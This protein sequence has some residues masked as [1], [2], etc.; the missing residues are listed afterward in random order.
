MPDLT[1]RACRPNRSASLSCSSRAAF[2]VKVMTTI[3]WG[4]TPC[5]W[6]SQATRWVRTRVF[7]LPGPAI[8]LQQMGECQRCYGAGVLRPGLQ[9]RGSG[10]S[11]QGLLN[12]SESAKALHVAGKWVI[13]GSG[14][15]SGQEAAN[16][17]VVSQLWPMRFSG[18]AGGYRRACLMCFSWEKTAACCSGL[19]PVVCPRAAVPAGC[20]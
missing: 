12:P 20:V 14:H 17:H 7:P 15:R 13:Y 5:C 8:S 1:V 18:S 16:L 6:I 11:Q 10:A 3:S 2:L 4:C 9:G 19:R